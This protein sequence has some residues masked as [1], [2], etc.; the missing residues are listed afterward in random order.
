MNIYN[1]KFYFD[2]KKVRRDYVFSLLSDIHVTNTAPLKLWNVLKEKIKESNPDYIFLP[3]DIVY[4]SDDF[5]DYDNSEILLKLLY[6]LNNIAPTYISLGNHEFKSGKKSNSSYSVNFLKTIYDKTGATILDSRLE[7]QTVDLGDITVSGFSPRVEA[8]YKINYEDWVSMFV[9]D[10]NNANLVFS[11]NKYNIL[12][13]HSP[14]LISNIE[15]L[16]E[17]RSKLANIDLILT[18]HRHDG[19]IPKWLQH[20]IFKKTD[21]GIDVSDGERKRDYIISV[22]DKCRGVH[23]VENSNMI[24][25]R[26][27][28]KFAHDNLL[29]NMLDRVSSKDIATIKLKKH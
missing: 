1:E 14:D 11:D 2:N 20:M 26:G 13:T 21:L 17:L 3:G 16:K 6:D 5:L 12:L 9:E 24:V 18:G 7:K 15:V 23:S 27:V 19:Y 22:V 28:R 10:Y 29:F 25:T 8:Y 4:T